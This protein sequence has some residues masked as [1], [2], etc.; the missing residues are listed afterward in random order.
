MPR[1]KKITQ[2]PTE[3]PASFYSQPLQQE[4]SAEEVLRNYHNLTYNHTASRRQEEPPNT[5]INSF[6]LTYSPQYLQTSYDPSIWNDLCFTSISQP[7]PIKTENKETIFYSKNTWALKIID[8]KITFNTEQLTMD[9]IT[10]EFLKTLSKL[11]H[12][13][14]LQYTFEL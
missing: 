9:E 6:N 14:G 7:T 12:K 3:Q 4:I 11:T 10:E 2:T 1:K 5:D 8:N 13:E